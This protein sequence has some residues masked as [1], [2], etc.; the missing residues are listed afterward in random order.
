MVGQT[1]KDLRKAEDDLRTRLPLGQKVAERTLLDFLTK[2]GYSDYVAQRTLHGLQM[3]GKVQYTH[4][5]KFVHRWVLR[6]FKCLLFSVGVWLWMLMMM[7]K[8]LLLLDNEL[9]SVRSVGQLLTAAHFQ[10][11]SGRWEA[12]WSVW[13]QMSALWDWAVRVVYE[14]INASVT[15]E[16]LSFSQRMLKSS[17]NGAE[18]G[19]VNAQIPS[20][21]SPL[22][23]RL[24]R[25]WKKLLYVRQAY[26]DNYV[27]HTFLEEMQKNGKL[28]RSLVPNSCQPMPDRTST[29]KWSGNPAWSHSTF[30]QSPS[31]LQHS[32]IFTRI[33]YLFTSWLLSR[34]CWLREDMRFGVSTSVERFQTTDSHVII[35]L[36]IFLMFCRNKDF[37]GCI[38][39]LY[40][41]VGIIANLENTD[42][43]HERWHNL[44]TDCLPILCQFVLSRL[45]IREYDK[46]KVSWLV[47]LQCRYIFICAVG[48]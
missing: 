20:E 28:Q 25:K 31:S 43:G 45:W 3:Q 24:R 42:A 29:G 26:P 14:R 37:E 5:G 17:L 18:F 38:A 8:T 44:G 48:I 15:R 10:L 11:L 36:E 2:R 40:D 21:A 19:N 22:D 4:Q 13:N 47:E 41:I 16:M 12:V 30:R 33:L 9:R 7:N 35:V 1:Q 32:C 6:T 23:G 46:H 27:D 34:T 39:V